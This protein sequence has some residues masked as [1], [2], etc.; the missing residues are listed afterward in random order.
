MKILYEYTEIQKFE[1]EVEKQNRCPIKILYMVDFFLSMIVC[2]TFKGNLSS[3][4]IFT[5]VCT[6][7]KFK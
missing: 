4:K 3:K 5:F 1:L 2:N 7:C 6:T